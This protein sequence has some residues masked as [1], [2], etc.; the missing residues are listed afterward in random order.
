MLGTSVLTTF[1]YL[2]SETVIQ[3]LILNRRIFDHLFDLLKL[4]EPLAK[5]Y[6]ASLRV[7]YYQCVEKFLNKSFQYIK[8]MKDSSGK[9]IL[10]SGKTGFLGFLVAIK[11][12]QRHYKELVETRP[13]KLNPFLPT[14][15]AKTT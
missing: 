15:W 10:T 14:K 2:N 3:P 12:V 5:D 9:S 1:N 11:N 7:S 13:Q 6:K 4:Q 8:N